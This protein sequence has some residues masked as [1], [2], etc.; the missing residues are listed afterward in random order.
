MSEP[1]FEKDPPPAPDAV[2][3]IIPYK[4]GAALTAYY[5]AV[6]SLVP[7]LGLV[8]G[9]PAIILGIIGLKKYRQNPAVKGTAHAWIGII[10]GSI[11]TLLWLGGIAFIVIS[12]SAG[13]Y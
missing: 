2:A 3:S 8:V 4:N 10:L 11:T 12:A 7:C 6:F 13:R 9:I 1:I 5:L